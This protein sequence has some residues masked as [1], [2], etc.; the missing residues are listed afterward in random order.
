MK[1]GSRKYA[2]RKARR[3]DKNREARKKRKEEDRMRE[4]ESP[5]L[6]EIKNTKR[7]GRRK[8]AQKKKQ[9]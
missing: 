1:F 5:N 8:A 6:E 3:R 7:C 9:I 2:K 4:R